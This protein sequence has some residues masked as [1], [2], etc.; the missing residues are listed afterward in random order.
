MFFVGSWKDQTPGYSSVRPILKKWDH[1]F[2]QKKHSNFPNGLQLKNFRICFLLHILRQNFS[3]IP[4]NWKLLNLRNKRG[5]IFGKRLQQ[6]LS[7]SV[8]CFCLYGF[9][10]WN[11][12]AIEAMLH[13]CIPV[14]SSDCFCRFCR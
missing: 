3:K 5:K 4:K 10:P 14:F 11:P 8:F 6:Q 12:R 9:H 7:N 2:S 13:G 1:S